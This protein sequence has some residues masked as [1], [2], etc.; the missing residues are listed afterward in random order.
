MKMSVRFVSAVLAAALSATTVIATAQ[1]GFPSATIR[2]VWGYTPGATGDLVA[3]LLAQNFSTQM[4]ATAVV[5]N[6]PGANGN[7]S[8]EFVAKSRPDGHTLL[9]NSPGLIVS[10]VIGEKLGYDLFKDLTPVARIA[11][12]PYFLIV[13]PSLPVNTVAEFVAHLKANPDKLTY[14]SSGNGSAPHLGTLLFLQ[15]HGL[16]SVHVPYKGTVPA[17]ADLIAG[18]IDYRFSDPGAVLAMVKDKRLK[19]IAFAGLKRSPLMPDLPTLVESGMAGFEVGTS[20]SMM[21]PA[22]T[23]PAIVKKISSEISKALQN[24]DMKNRLI[25]EGVELLGTSPEEYSAYLKTEVDRWSRVVKIAG[26][27]PEE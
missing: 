20:F 24:P 25:Q 4:N 13:A 6:K 10:R 9:F 26:V 7:I 22:N 19:A 23:P 11:S 18:R 5:D 3:R 8:A 16:T 27:K 1:D 12:A 2:I 14:A 21:A 17:T 15:A